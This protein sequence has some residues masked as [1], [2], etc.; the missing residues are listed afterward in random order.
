MEQQLILAIASVVAVLLVGCAIALLIL[1]GMPCDYLRAS[2]IAHPWRSGYGVIDKAWLVVKNVLGSMLVLIGGILSMPLIPGPGFL[3]VVAGI[4]LLDFPA[5][6]RML[7]K[8]VGRP[9]VLRSINRLR[10]A[11][12]RE[13]LLVD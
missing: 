8:L 10:S 2:R 4:L 11:F 12:A 13:P 3:I 9:I 6:H 5:K 7:R 1:I